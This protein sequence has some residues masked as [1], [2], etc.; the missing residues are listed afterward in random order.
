MLGWREVH[1]VGTHMGNTQLAQG[2]VFGS[3]ER[4]VGEYL[5]IY[6]FF[7]IS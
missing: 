7:A 4:G 5:F 1:R 6:L 2:A 3:A